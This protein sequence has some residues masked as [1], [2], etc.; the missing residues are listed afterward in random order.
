MWVTELSFEG[1]AHKGKIKGDFDRLH[2]CYGN[3]VSWKDAFN[4]FINDGHFFA[5]NILPSI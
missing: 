2:R 3:F 1:L 4:P 5:S